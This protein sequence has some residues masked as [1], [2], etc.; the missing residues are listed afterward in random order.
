MSLL[1][2]EQYDLSIVFR[3][4]DLEFLSQ[5]IFSYQKLTHDDDVLSYLPQALDQSYAYHQYQWNNLSIYNQ[6]VDQLKGEDAP[7][8]VFGILMEC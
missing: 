5:L 3:D 1:N 8:R 2:S 4:F 6:Y 7:L